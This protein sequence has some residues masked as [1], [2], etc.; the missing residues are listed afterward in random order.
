MRWPVLI[1]EVMPVN[2]QEKIAAAETRKLNPQNIITEETS[3]DRSARETEELYLLMEK[4]NTDLWAQASRNKKKGAGI[5]LSLS[6]GACFPANTSRTEIDK[7][8]GQIKDDTQLNIAGNRGDGDANK[9]DLESPADP[10][11]GVR[12]QS[13]H[14]VATSGKASDELGDVRQCPNAMEM[15]GDGVKT[16]DHG[17]SAFVCAHTVFCQI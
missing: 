8:Q 2:D 3:V 1:V 9:A 4:A 16:T 10:K 15:P 13:S 12:L 6:S 5:S 17:T 14:L 11:L 7:R